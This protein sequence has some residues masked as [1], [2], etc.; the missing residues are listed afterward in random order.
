MLPP[1]I[2]RHPHQLLILPKRWLPPSSLHLS[3]PIPRL[4]SIPLQLT[5]QQSVSICFFLAIRSFLHSFWFFCYLFQTAKSE[6]DDEDNEDSED[7]KN[8]TDESS[9]VNTIYSAST[10]TYTPAAVKAPAYIAP[11]CNKA[12]DP[13]Y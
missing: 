4:H 9:D 3:H 10:Y 13:K 12:A 5:L 11:V 2:S 6:V 7:D 1:P 8:D